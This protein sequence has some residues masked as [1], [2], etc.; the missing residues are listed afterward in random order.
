M[1]ERYSREPAAGLTKKRQSILLCAIPPFVPFFF[2]LTHEAEV[3]WLYIG[4]W[5]SEVVGNM[6]HD[7]M[8]MKIEHHGNGCLSTDT[9]PQAQHIKFFGRFD[10]VNWKRKM[11]NGGIHCERP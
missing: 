3:P 1:F 7:L 11:K 9:A 6:R 2:R 5:W 4:L 10:V 8:A